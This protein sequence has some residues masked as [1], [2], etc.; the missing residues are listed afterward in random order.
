MYQYMC[1]H[2]FSIFEVYITCRQTR[3]RFLVPSSTFLAPLPFNENVECDELE[4]IFSLLL[5]S[6]DIFIKVKD[7]IE[8]VYN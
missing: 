1:I 6:P 4:Y 2:F 8:L 5:I 7:S 3:N